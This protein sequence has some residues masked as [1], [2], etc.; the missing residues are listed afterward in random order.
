MLSHRTEEWEK[1]VS[2]TK[3]SLLPKQAGL[4]E[5]LEQVVEKK[6]EE[7]PLFTP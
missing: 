6:E 5:Q 7:K 2:L 4:S 1:N 3:M